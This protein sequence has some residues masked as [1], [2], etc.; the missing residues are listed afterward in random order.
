MLEPSCA[1]FGYHF[2]RPF[3]LQSRRL[4]AAATRGKGIHRST[5]KCFDLCPEQK[6]VC[7]LNASDFHRTISSKRSVGLLTKFAILVH[8]LLWAGWAGWPGPG[9]VLPGVQSASALLALGSCPDPGTSIMTCMH[10]SNQ[11]DSLGRRCDAVA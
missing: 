2:C 6:W 11:A 3:C 9:Q 7:S 5:T 4:Q 8:F 10:A 1:N